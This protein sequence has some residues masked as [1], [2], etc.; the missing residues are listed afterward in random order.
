M[1]KQYIILASILLPLGLAA[2]NLNPE[3]QVTNEYQTRIEDAAKQGPQMKIPDS[4]LRFDYHFDYSVFDSPY[5]GSYEFSPYS[6]T[7]TPDPKIY[8]GRKLYV[9]GGLGY[10]L[11]P[12]LDVVWAAVD[13][14]KVAVN[15]F[16]SGKGYYGR[17]R[18]IVPLALDLQK[19]TYDKGYDFRT[20]LGADARFNLGDYVLRA[21]AGYDGVYNK[22]EIFH[23]VNCHAPYVSARVGY[24]KPG[25]FSW[26]AGAKYRYVY[27]WLNGK[28]PVNDH[29]VQ[30]DGTITPYLFEDYHLSADVVFSHN[31]FYTAAGIHP[32][33]VFQLGRFDFDAG[34]R[35]GWYTGHATFSPDIT[36]NMH[37]LD[38]YLNIYAGAV[39]KD[40]LM[41][42]WDYK[43]R[44]HRYHVSYYGDPRPV[45]EVADLFLGVRGHA[46]F[47]LQ[48]DLKGG[49]EILKD[50]PFWA[51]GPVGEESLGFQDCNM[52]HA[53]LLVS[54]A[55]ERFNLDGNVHYIHIPGGVADRVFAPAAVIGQIK[56]GYNWKK[57][58][59]AGLSVDMSTK[60][61][62]TLGNTT[63]KIPGYVDV[64]VW[65]EYK[66]NKRLSFWLQG[67][68]LLAHDIRISPMISECGPAII[69]GAAFSL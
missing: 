27:D 33:A 42:L 58:I 23:T 7:I 18:H 65:S 14:K 68:N 37:L 11:K 55:S 26:S 49:Y 45:R 67:S 60:R 1:K 3:V 46:D 8:D 4:L 57:R 20:L 41:T 22:H 9:R 30:V 25:S 50:A 12:E 29:E 62:A 16:A 32:H 64:G 53:D 54:W 44:A 40:N 24:D 21:E 10:V 48:Y 66:Y 56:G 36:V 15:V 59:Y 51:L 63:T 43:T 61:V 34:F 38:D 52:I 35:A 47:G 6:V 17:Y 13:Q 5:K 39:G 69:V 28:A 31:L 2:Q 19:N